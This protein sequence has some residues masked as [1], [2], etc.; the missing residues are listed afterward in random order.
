VVD[1]A[2]PA[3]IR[4]QLEAEQADLAREL[5]EIELLLQ[6]TRPEAERYEERRL[7][8]AARVAMLEREPGSDAAELKEAH[9][10]LVAQTRRATF[11]ESQVQVLEGKQKALSRF[12]QQIALVLPHLG[13]SAGGATDLSAAPQA[14]PGSRAVLAAQ[15]EMRRD[16]AR[17]MHDGPAQ[18]IANIALQAQ[19]VQ[20]LF[21]RDPSG[22]AT[23][24]GKLTEMVEHALE[25]T[26]D[27]IF[28]VRPM[29]LDDLG[30][31][32]TLRRACIEHSRRENVAVRFESTGTDRRLDA[33]LES[34]LFRI[35]DDALTGFLA[36]RPAELVVRLD[37]V[38]DSVRASAESIA[39]DEDEETPT[40]D[41]GGEQLPPALANVI[42]EPQAARGPSAG[43]RRQR[44]HGLAADLWTDIQARASSVGIAVSLDE[45]GRLLEARART[46][47]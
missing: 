36:G 23:E 38:P 28:D 25:A 29:V 19:V 13:S 5:D 24:L 21:Q 22:A 40:A 37:W 26:K 33:D 10:Q 3:D 18:S 7:Q 1:A 42:G 30:L 27:F 2:R 12:Q 11:M 46:T 47:D 14:A 32:P 34:N 20:R 39:A 6:Q 16:I 15:E 8:S 45:E 9:D 41:Q 35:V 4:A 31:V 44:G 17:Q 43:G